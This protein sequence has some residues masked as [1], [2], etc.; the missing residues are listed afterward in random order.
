MEFVSALMMLFIV[1]AIIWTF[2]KS[3]IKVTLD[4]INAK[5]D[6]LLA[7]QERERDAERSPL[8]S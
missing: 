5:L 1:C 7:L 6:R 2:M 8:D 4:P 3:L